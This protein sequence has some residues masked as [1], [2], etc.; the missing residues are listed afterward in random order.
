VRQGEDE[1]P[2]ASLGV[3]GSLSGQITE[4][5]EVL[6]REQP[7]RSKI[8]LWAEAMSL[9]RVRYET[10]VLSSRQDPDGVSRYHP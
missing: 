6:R 1:G 10:K 2:L 5:Y 9:H 3:S 8:E 7:D 4:I